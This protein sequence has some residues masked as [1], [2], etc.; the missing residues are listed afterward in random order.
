MSDPMPSSSR[1]PLEGIAVGISVSLGQDSAAFGFSDE[2]MN[3]AIVRLS[4][5][6][7]AD[8]ARLVFGH[9][10][11]P[12]GVMAAITQ[13]AVSYDPGP[14]ARGGDGTRF[15]RITNLVPWD[16]QPELPKDLRADLEG[17]AILKI[18]Q[19][20]LGD[21]PRHLADGKEP[22][23]DVLVG[24]ALRTL[25]RRLVERCHARVCL[26]GKMSGYQG[27]V[28]GILEEAL[29]CAQHPLHNCLLLSGLMGGAARRI[30]EAS[31]SGAW[32][33]LVRL[34]LAESVEREL[35]PGEVD[36]LRRH[37]ANEAPDWLSEDSLIQRSG[38][39]A[40]DWHRLTSASDIEVVSAF[41]LKALRARAA[42]FRAPRQGANG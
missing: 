30:L 37:F 20:E 39:S 35:G 32:S 40:D 24:V 22:S 14:G 9:D 29:G 25:R 34:P 15:C 33:D 18:E 7:L 5:A 10:W 21:L 3:R 23:R 42:S 31:Y 28:P 11:R 41:V 16:R 26:G 13:L 1:L 6:L 12:S 8:G 19:V 38:L 4:R 2:D 27:F 36:G 17:R